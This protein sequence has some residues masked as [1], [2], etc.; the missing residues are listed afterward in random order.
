[1]SAW[2]LFQRLEPASIAGTRGAECAGITRLSSK[3][4]SSRDLAR[5]ALEGLQLFI[6]QYG[7]QATTARLAGRPFW[8][9]AERR[10]L[11]SSH[12]EPPRSTLA[13]TCRATPS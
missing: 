5:L 12:R 13:V 8:R 6:D 3:R 4:P 11:P 1:M 7:T 10:R 2:R 9:A